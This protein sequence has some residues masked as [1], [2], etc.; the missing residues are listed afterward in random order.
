MIEVYAIVK[1]IKDPENGRFGELI[2]NTEVAPLFSTQE[3]A[4][5]FM[6]NCKESHLY[7]I[8]AIGMV[9]DL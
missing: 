7:S 5:S 9:G 2:I 6:E 3:G 8:V 4:I 1:N